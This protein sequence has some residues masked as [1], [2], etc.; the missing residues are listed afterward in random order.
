MLPS[1]TIYREKGKKKKHTSSITPKNTYKT[2][3]SIQLTGTHT[4]LYFLTFQ[5]A[6]VPSFHDHA[7]FMM[8]PRQTTARG[9]TLDLDSATQG[10]GLDRAAYIPALSLGPPET[11]MPHPGFT[12]PWPLCWVDLNSWASYLLLD[13]HSRLASTE[14]G[15][16]LL[17]LGAPG[18]LWESL[19]ALVPLAK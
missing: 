12:D 2:S 3:R 15:A 10:T 14:T 7:T 13:L 6:S 8:S 9:K 17:T 19:G 11:R 16:F 18:N 4:L 5:N 1:R